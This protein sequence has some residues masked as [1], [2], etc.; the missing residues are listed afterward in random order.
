MNKGAKSKNA[1]FLFIGKK[2]LTLPKLQTIYQ[3]DGVF[4]TF[5]S[6]WI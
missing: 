5:W 3:L 2:F 1:G 6:K 4:L